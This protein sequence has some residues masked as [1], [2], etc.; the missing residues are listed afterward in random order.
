MGDDKVLIIKKAQQGDRKAM[1]LI[2]EEY[3]QFVLD[4]THRY[5][6]NSSEAKDVTQD[7]FIRVFDKMRG[8]KF[9][10]EFGAWLNVVSRNHI[11]SYIRKEKKYRFESLDETVPEEDIKEEEP[12]SSELE[13]YK[14]NLS[15][16][17]LYAMLKQL[18]EKSR[19]IF[20][21]YAIEGM[22]HKEIG[23]QLGISDGTSKSQL[24]RARVKFR[25]LLSIEYERINQQK[26]NKSLIIALMYIISILINGTLL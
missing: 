23:L 3:Y 8:F 16:P 15:V 13:T 21:L 7:I 2:Y 24:S 14:N 4:Y 20:N 19:T 11:I 26:K 25:E 18:D 17:E 1:R 22:T 5:L 6:M 10:S 12:E 9:E